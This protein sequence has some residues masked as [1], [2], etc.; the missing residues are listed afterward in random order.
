M[1]RDY[2]VKQ[3]IDD[4]DDKKKY[5]E[6]PYIEDVYD[7]DDPTIANLNKRLGVTDEEQ[8]GIHSLLKF[9]NCQSEEVKDIYNKMPFCN[10]WKMYVLNARSKKE[11]CYDIFFVKQSTVVHSDISHYIES[12]RKAYISGADDRC[13]EH[14]D[15]ALSDACD[16][17]I[18]LYAWMG[19]AYT[20]LAMKCAH[21]KEKRHKTAL[22]ANYFR[23]YN[24]LSGMEEEDIEYF[25][26]ARYEQIVGKYLP[27][28]ERKAQIKRKK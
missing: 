21:L 23:L 27:E 14:L 13:V 3:I 22:A 4:F 9:S 5:E 11:N 16:P 25:D 20:N 6:R 10:G 1:K 19:C 8:Q 17:E 7:D 24:Y 2:R 15:H 26:Y 12:A 28:I 18:V